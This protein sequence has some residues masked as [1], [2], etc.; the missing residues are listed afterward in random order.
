MALEGGYN[1]HTLPWLVAGIVAAMGDLPDETIDP[2]A[3]GASAPLPSAHDTRLRDVID[4]L[5][6]FWRF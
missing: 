1:Q 5:R 3:P 2:F 4:V 6:P